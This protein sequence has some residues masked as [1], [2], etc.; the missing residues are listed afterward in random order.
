[1]SETI[2]HIGYPKTG[3]TWFV[4]RFFPH[5]KNARLYYYNDIDFNVTTG[6]EYFNVRED[7]AE[8]E[9]EKRIIVSHVFTGLVDLQWKDGIYR[10]FF[11][12]NLKSKYPDAKI[13]LFIRNQLDF[14]ASAYSTYLKKGGKLTA[15]NL[16]NIKR[17]KNGEFFSIEYLKYDVLINMV[18][19][20]FGEANVHVYIYEDF[21]QDNMRFSERFVCDL[22]LKID[23]N[24]LKYYRENDQLRKGLSALI[25]LTNGFFGIFHNPSNKY[26]GSPTIYKLGKEKIDWINSFKIW[27]KKQNTYSLL[28]EEIVEFLTEYYKES[29]ANLKSDP[30][31]VDIEKYRYPIQ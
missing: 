28:G 29:N 15:R 12:K 2:I 14:I 22:G 16:F 25:R 5:V 26:F 3:T 19:K 17:L 6:Q 20:E 18:K 30:S 31:M 1:M 8:I 11:L 24:K 13:V 27:G 23:L 7:R 10:N 4:N 9:K 21:Q